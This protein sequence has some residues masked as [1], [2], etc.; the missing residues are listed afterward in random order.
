MFNKDFMNLTSLTA[1]VN[2]EP[3][4]E[5]TLSRFFTTGRVASTDV[6]IER[7][8]TTLTLIDP[9]ARGV[10]APNAENFKPGRTHFTIESVKLGRVVNFNAAHLQN[11]RAFG[12]EDQL[13]TWEQVLARDTR[14]VRRWIENTHEFMRMK[15]L[16]GIQVDSEDNE[17]FNFFTAAG[18][19]P[20][21]PIEIDYDGI[22]RRQL[23]NVWADVADYVRDGLDGNPDAARGIIILHGKNS[24]RRFRSS[25]PVAALYE[26]FQEGAVNRE[27][28]GGQRRVFNIFDIG[29]MQYFGAG[30]GDDE[31]QAVPVVDGLFNTDFTPLDNPEVANTLGLPLYATPEE[32]PFGKSWAVELASLPIHSVTQPG[33]LIGGT[34]TGSID[35]TVPEEPEAPEGGE[36]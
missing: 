5:T 15:T 20:Y 32:M 28:I 3:F 11:V 33:C 1:S 8:G 30:L 13:E 34:S 26:R 4:K 12:T 35:G 31:W 10:P 18:V 24:W 22:T 17:L 29:H 25:D 21:T 9:T 23:Q 6:K 16:K 14:T 19:T 2:K 27:G 7:Q 36:S